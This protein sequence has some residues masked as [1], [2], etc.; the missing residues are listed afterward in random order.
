MKKFKAIKMNGYRNSIQIRTLT[1]NFVTYAYQKED[2]I[3]WDFN[4]K[5][6]QLIYNYY[7]FNS[8]NNTA[9]LFKTEKVNF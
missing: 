2:D 8:E 4:K 9:V 1:D 5:D 3:Y 6:G 7:S